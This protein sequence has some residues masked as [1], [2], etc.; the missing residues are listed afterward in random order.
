MQLAALLIQLEKFAD[1]EAHLRWCVSRN[2][3][4]HD[5]KTLL[6]KAVKQR[7]ATSKRN[8]EVSLP[9]KKFH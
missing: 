7:I 3:D 5:A 9:R 1:A 8:T 4:S 2:P 6:A